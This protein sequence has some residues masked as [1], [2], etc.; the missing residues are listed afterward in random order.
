LLRI[1]P[2]TR[3]ILSY[4]F[5]WISILII[6]A[7]GGGLSLT[8][9]NHRPFS[10]V[11]LN[12]SF[13]HQ[14]EKISSTILW[15]VSLVVPA[16]IIFFVCLVFVPGRTASAGTPSK[17]KWRRKLWELNTGWMGLGLSLA[18]SVLI[19]QGLKNLFG[20][21]RPDMLSRCLPNLEQIVPLAGGYAQS[22]NR[23]WVLVD[24]S[25]CTQ[26]DKSYL[27]DGFKSF[28]SGHA[29]N[30]WSGLF[31]LAL[32]LCSKFA[33]FIPFTPTGP[34][35]EL[36]DDLLLPLSTHENPDE[37][38]FSSIPPRNRAAAPPV[39][40]LALP[41]VPI[42]V[43][44]YIT[45]TRYFQFFHFGIDATIGTLVGIL[46][47]WFSF[48]FYHMPISRGAGWSWGARTRDRAWG[49]GIGRGGYVGLEGWRSS[50]RSR[51]VEHLKPATANGM[52]AGVRPHD[53]LVGP[54][55]HDSSGIGTQRDTQ[56]ISNTNLDREAKQ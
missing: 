44:I 24:Y 48:R 56:I 14:H 34:N 49:I 41:L 55:L 2:S 8:K 43:A 1:L 36:S 35:T 5:D 20:K 6:A 22:F 29:S 32:F 54:G 11:D 42:A 33:I 46:T 45:S 51:D 39:Y 50:K 47:S 26:T 3:L 13:P 27:D 19:T 38:K 4:V 53:D 17:L 12:I 9:P 31:Y 25:I 37:H 28:P 30:S 21:P 10:L 15:I 16:A 40:L 18:L 7:I 52:N 23:E